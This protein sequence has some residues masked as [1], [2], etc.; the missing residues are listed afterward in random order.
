MKKYEQNRHLNSYYQ[1]ADLTD[2]W[3]GDLVAMIAATFGPNW[4]NE[5]MGAI[6]RQVHRGKL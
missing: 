4:M 1:M 2:K 5:L 3:G 6:E